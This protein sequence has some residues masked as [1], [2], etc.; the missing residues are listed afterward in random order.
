LLFLLFK[1]TDMNITTRKATRQDIP[2][3]LSLIKELAVYEKAPNEVTITPADLE[4]DGFGKRPLYEAI[5]AEHDGKV[6]GMA[7]YFISYSTWKGRCLFLE[8][9]IVKQVYRNKGIGT[10]LFNKVIEKAREIG[11]KR[12]QWQVLEWNQPAIE[13]YKKYKANI[14]PE[15]LNCKLT[16]E[17]IR[18]L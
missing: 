6:V 18:D 8:D 7:F 10:I 2:D 14:D 15:W 9:I 13:F 16:E 3:I 1:L 4:E 17:Q 5:L 11:A 12:L